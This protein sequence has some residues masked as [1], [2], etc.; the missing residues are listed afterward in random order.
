MSWLYRRLLQGRHARHW[1]SN[2]QPRPFYKSDRTER[3]GG[4]TTPANSSCISS[5]KSNYASA[6]SLIVNVATDPH[7]ILNTP[8]YDFNLH[9]VP[10]VE[11]RAIKLQYDEMTRWIKKTCKSVSGMNQ[12][13]KFWEY[14][15][16]FAPNLA[17]VCTFF[18]SFA[19]IAIISSTYL[20]S[21]TNSDLSKRPRL[22]N[23][24]R[25]IR[26]QR[27]SDSPHVHL[28]SSP[29]TFPPN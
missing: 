17:K 6:C 21:S 3:K 11:G 27:L 5:S 13:F 16:W 12:S 1:P 26:T 19:I 14:R 2:S 20:H 10:D 8:G 23:P 28:Y 15:T 9:L 4:S 25:K 18:F 22:S 24:L 7:F 29:S